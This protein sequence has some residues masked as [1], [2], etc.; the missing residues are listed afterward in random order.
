[1]L[2]VERHLLGPRICLFGV[3]LHEWPLGAALL[4]ALV[5]GFVFGEVHDWLTAGLTAAAGLW[6][7]A[8][9]W[10]DLTPS[11]RDTGSWRLGLHRRPH[12]LRRAR[13]AE[14]LPAIAALAAAAVGAV[15]LVSAVTPNIRSRGD[16]LLVFEPLDALRVFHP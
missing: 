11:R 12:A 16:L 9:D 13:P 2:R 4:L 14:P 1:M 6:L 3:R 7:V 10:R 8:K 15:N 5:V